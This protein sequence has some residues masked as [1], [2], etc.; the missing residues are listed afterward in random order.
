MKVRAEQLASHLQKQAMPIYWVAGD[1]I[2]LQQE[3]CDLIRQHYKNQG[4]SERELMSV[5]N[6]FD[7]SSFLQCCNSLSLFAERKIIELRLQAAKLNDKGRKALNTYL[8]Q[9]SDDN[10]IL[11][12]GGKLDSGTINTKWFKAIESK[13]VFVQ[14]W[15]VETHKLPQWISQRLQKAGLKANSEA[16]K[17]L[18]ERVEGNLLA[19]A[20]EI[21]KLKILSTSAVVDTNTILNV[22]ANSSRY[23]V[24]NLLDS[25]LQG[26]ASRSLRMLNG[27]KSEGSEPLMILGIVNRELR[28]LAIMAEK[29][30]QGKNINSVMQS[31][32]VWN[33]RQSS[34]S[35]ALSKHSPTDLQSMLQDA[36]AIDQSVKGIMP[37]RPWDLLTSL[38]LKLAGVRTA[39]SH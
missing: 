15:P 27:L 14:I 16:I 22:V 26:N 2:L 28:S 11:I 7:W 8:Q 20:Q 29:V 10:V 25:T 1:E 24:F 34:V 3:S 30:Q 18:A 17:I 4:F 6:S 32:G 36:K 35:S 38:L 19:A 9:P 5:D 23:N 21:E 39:T 12:S 37:G 31:H 13:G 33:N